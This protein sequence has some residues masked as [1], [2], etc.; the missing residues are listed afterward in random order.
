M[1]YDPDLHGSVIRNIRRE[2]RSRFHREL[3]LPAV[4]IWK[5]YEDTFGVVDEEHPDDKERVLY[6]TLAEEPS[7]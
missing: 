4:D 6:D 2:Y 7:T 3:G 5:I 1:R